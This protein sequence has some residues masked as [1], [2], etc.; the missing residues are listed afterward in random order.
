MKKALIII[1]SILGVVVFSL[2]GFFY[3]MGVFSAVVIEEKEMGPFTFAYVEHLGPYSEVGEPMMKLDEKLRAA[4]F[5][6]ISGIGIYY[7]DPSQ[8]PADNLRSEVGSIIREEDLD[9]IEK[10]QDEFNFTTLERRNYLVS[11]FPYKNMLSFLFGPLR[12]YPEFA[13]Y[14]Q[15]HN[16]EIPEKGIE[17]YDME[18]NKILFMMELE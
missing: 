2:L 17:Y 8:T 12:V 9:L 18:Q 16:M 15:A 14:L 13:V 11:E 4:G 3:Y 7:D 6:S 10:H 1:G 5:S